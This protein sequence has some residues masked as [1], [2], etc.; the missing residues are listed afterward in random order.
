MDLKK[1]ELQILTFIME[2]VHRQGYPPSVREIAEG[3]GLK[4]TASVYLYI[5]SLDKKGYIKKDKRKPRALEIMDI[6]YSLGLIEKDGREIVEIPILGQI[7][8]GEP[9]LAQENIEDHFP[10]PLEFLRVKRENL[11]I[12]KVKG[13]SMKEIGIIEGDLAIMKQQNTATN[14]DIVAALIEDEAT[15]KRFY[16]LEDHVRL[17]PENSS[18]EP[19]IVENVIILGLLIGL[20]RTYH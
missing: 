9:V 20:F 5:N 15:I 13:D 19:I 17:Q 1:R 14:G 4:S 12:V 18:Y 3:V 10:I 7:T 6:S 11:F 16:R 2:R 8:A